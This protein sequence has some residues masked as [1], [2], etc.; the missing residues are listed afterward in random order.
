MFRPQWHWLKIVFD[1]T[2]YTIWV[3][4]YQFVLVSVFWSSI[5]ICSIRLTNIVL[6]LQNTLQ[7][8]MHS[9]STSANIFSSITNRV[10]ATIWLLRLLQSPFRQILLQFLWTLWQSE[11][12]FSTIELS[13]KISYQVINLIVNSEINC[14]E[15]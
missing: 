8:E 6:Y 12:S 7:N 9:W 2:W 10:S 14:I 4:T 1:I 15:E 5:N 11:I 13:Q 3:I